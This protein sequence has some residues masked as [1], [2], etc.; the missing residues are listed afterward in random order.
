MLAWL[1]A[2]IIGLTLGLLGSGGSILTVPVLVY[3]LGEPEKLAIAESLLIVGS[4]AL[5]GSIPHVLG[6]LI[7]WREVLLLGLP[8]LLGSWLGAYASRWILD[9][10]QL[11]LLALV[12]LVAATLMSRN[13]PLKTEVGISSWQTALVGFGIGT[14]TGIVGVGGGFLIVPAL[15]LLARL[16]IHRAVGSSLLI[17]TFNSSSGLLK[18]ISWL[19]ERGMVIH[20]G[21]VLPFIFIGILGSFAGHRAALRLSQP[22]LRRGFAGFLLLVGAF[23]LWQNL[24]KVL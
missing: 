15:V 6:R 22:M 10:V 19:H 11:G 24:P 8:G 7:A 9:A 17:I 1:G 16:P 5:V 2:L 3:L 21:L 12:M 18:H 13:T 14:L 20:W 23:I 4:I